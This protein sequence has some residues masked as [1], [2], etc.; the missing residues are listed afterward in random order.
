MSLA[1]L[2]A[3]WRIGENASASPLLSKSAV[4]LDAV[5]GTKGGTKVDGIDSYHHFILSI[6]M[7][8]KNEC[9]RHC[10]AIRYSRDNDMRVCGMTG[11]YLPNYKALR[12]YN[13]P[14]VE[15]DDESAT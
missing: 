15:V 5:A 8:S 11:E 2:P 10:P 6:H 7:P 9:C 14:L 12:G 3:G 1:N 4:A 13:C